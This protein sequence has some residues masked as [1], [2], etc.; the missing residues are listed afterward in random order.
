MTTII[1]TDATTARL[2]EFATSQGPHDVAPEVVHEATRRVLDTLG[3]G[4]GG[5]DSAPARI[6]RELAQES[7]GTRGARVF[8]LEQRSTPEM[9]AFANGVMIRFLDFNDVN[10]EITAGGHPSDMIPAVL[11]VAD[12]NQLSGLDALFGV[13]MAY[14]AYAAIPVQIKP[15]GWDQAILVAVGTATGLGAMLRLTREQVGHAIS[16]SLTP[17]LALCVTRRGDLSM[18]KAGASAA[19]ARSAVFGTLLAAK[20]MT[21]P[22]RPF[23]GTH[24]L[25]DQA[26]GP[27]ELELDPGSFGWRVTQSDIK[28]FPSCGSTQAILTTFLEMSDGIRPEDVEAIDVQ[29]H[30]GAWFE[31]GKEPEKWDPKS[32]ETADHSLPFVIATALRERRVTPASFTDEAVNDP[33]L[34]PIMQKIRITENPELTARRPAETLSDIEIRM[35]SGQLVVARTGIPRGAHKNPLTDDELEQKFRSMAEPMSVK[36]R[37]DGFLTELWQ[38]DEAPNVSAVMDH[39]NATL[40]TAR[41][42]SD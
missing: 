38:L 30:W 8:G 39:W 17:N 26:T 40:G 36:R 7:T 12:A 20:G 5:V 32:R 16:L 23:E 24:G 9:A 19:T 13:T 27:F 42:E 33:S 18:W 31:T 37:L 6:A 25:W 35:R 4:F 34:R 3:C 21:G 41:S 10:K 14:Q 2:A 29:T 28:C 15:R 11:A 1:D 22:A